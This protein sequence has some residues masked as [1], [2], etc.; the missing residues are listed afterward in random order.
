MD[1]KENRSYRTIFLLSI[2]VVAMMFI[3]SGYVWYQISGDAGEQGESAGKFLTV[4]AVPILI[5]VTVGLLPLFAR[6]EPR[7]RHIAQSHKALTTIWATLLIYF[8]IVHTVL[9]LDN[10]GYAPSIATYWPILVGLVAMVMGNYLG[11][12]SSNHFAG[13]RTPWTL[14]SELS[15]NKTHRL[16][17]KLLFLL[18]LALIAGSIIVSGEFWS[19]FILFASLLWVVVLAI[20]SYFIWKSDPDRTRTKPSSTA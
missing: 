8:L 12:I 14:S 11:K 4:F 7:Q 13:F 16:G 19:Y 15:W 5:A 6:I 9:L 3:M 17:G 18:G 1:S 10:L 20:Y 2:A